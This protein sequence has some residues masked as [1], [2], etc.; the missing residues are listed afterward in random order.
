MGDGPALHPR[1]HRDGGQIVLSLP[2]RCEE[3]T[4]GYEKV[5]DE[6]WREMRILYSHAAEGP[7]SGKI[8]LKCTLGQPIMAK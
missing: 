7:L 2:D 3:T 6:A 4:G 5:S 8:S 1:R